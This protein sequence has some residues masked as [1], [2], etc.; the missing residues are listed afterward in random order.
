MP[1]QTAIKCG[2]P[3]GY[4]KHIRDSTETCPRCRKAIAKYMRS[5]RHATGR[6]KHHI[7]PDAI[8]KQ[9]GI[10]VGK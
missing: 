5:Y 6:S 1:Q 9:H 2:T 4:R 8:V 3:Q 10:Q 7:I